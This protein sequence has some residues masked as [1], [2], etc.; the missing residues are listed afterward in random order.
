MSDV[1]DH[2]AEEH[3]VVDVKQIFSFY[4]EAPPTWFEYERLCER[5]GREVDELE[6]MKLHGHDVENLTKLVR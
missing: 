3:P 5:L 1:N 2:C 4:G 6:W